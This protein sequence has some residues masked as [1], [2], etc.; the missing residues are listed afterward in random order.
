MQRAA[1]VVVGCAAD[2]AVVTRLIPLG[3][4]KVKVSPAGADVV[5]AVTYDLYVITTG[6]TYEEISQKATVNSELLYT[7]P[8]EVN[9]PLSYVEMSDAQAG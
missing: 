3:R 7:E 1:L 2:A 9:T 8:A 4:A 5:A 6:S